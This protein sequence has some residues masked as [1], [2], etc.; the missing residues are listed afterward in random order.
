M[1]GKKDERVKMLV[2]YFFPSELDFSKITI[3]YPLGEKF[4][5]LK[6]TG[7]AIVTQKIEFGIHKFLLS[8]GSQE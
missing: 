1:T 3:V 2:A 6:E 7:S 8:Q 5:L 4:A